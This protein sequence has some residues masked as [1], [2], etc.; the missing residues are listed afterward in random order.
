MYAKVS[1]EKGSIHD[2]KQKETTPHN[3]SKSYKNMPKLSASF[4]SN[5][6]AAANMR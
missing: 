4:A 6:N 2:L 1:P 5:N 3:P